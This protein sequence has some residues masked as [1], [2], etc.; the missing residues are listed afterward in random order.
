MTLALVFPGQGAQR[1]GM[2]HRLPRSRQGLIQVAE[3]VIGS[4][5]DDTPEALG[6]TRAAQLALLVAGTAYARDLLSTGLRPA[7][8]AGHS[9]G[10]WTAAVIAEA[11]TFED[12]VRLV[13]VRARAMAHTA[14]SG[15]MIAVDGLPASAVDQ[16]CARLR[17]DG[18][19][20]WMSNINTAT[21]TTAS[22]TRT[23]LDRLT[24]ALQAA[25]A[26]RVIP[27][28]VEVPAHCPLMDQAEQSVGEQLAKHTLRPPRIPIAGNVTGQTL[29]TADRLREDL[30]AG[31]SRGV[32]WDAA[33]AILHERGVDRWIQ[34]PPGRSLLPLLPE[35]DR[36][37]TLDEIGIDEAAAWA[38]RGAG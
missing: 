5:L 1:P 35:T 2:L 12:A 32:R 25:G 7:Y 37:I 11:I 20:V 8:L 6:H 17:R 22:G 33:V 18:A 23:D 15:G 31:I 9:L 34:I 27:L 38:G 10:L 26:R 21:Q 4:R 16:C 3:E 24:L 13:S 36:R 28:D 30:T 29:F 19:R 14:G